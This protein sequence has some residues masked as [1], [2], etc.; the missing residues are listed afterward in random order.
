MAGPTVRVA[1][2]WFSDRAVSITMLDGNGK[3]IFVSRGLVGV[4]REQLPGARVQ[5]TDSTVLVETLTPDRSLLTVVD[6]ITTK[7]LAEILTH[8]NRNRVTVPTVA[9]HA[10]GVDTT[11]EPG[12]EPA[13]RE[14]VIPVRYTGAD[15]HTVAAILNCSTDELVALHTG[16]LWRVAYLG[17][18]PG[19]PYLT[20]R[21]PTRV[22]SD[23]DGDAAAAVPGSVWSRI[24]RLTSPRVTVPAGSVAVAAGMSAIYP[25]VLPGG[26]QL[27]GTTSTQLFDVSNTHAP[28]LLAAGDTVRFVNTP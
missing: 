20:P 7:Y 26:W 23:V 18:A 19:F 3:R 8:P 2:A 14:H 21:E 17:F 10:G 12:P 25:S 11:P 28:A 5:G 6:A 27:L 15:L 22:D 9:G 24:P 13:G 16:T 4:L 1:V